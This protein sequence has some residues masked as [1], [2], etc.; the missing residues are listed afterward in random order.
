MKI[1]DGLT[2]IELMVVLLIAG[3]AGSYALDVIIEHR[4]EHDSSGATCARKPAQVQKSG[5]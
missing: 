2:I 1:Q 5:S 3:I 4:C